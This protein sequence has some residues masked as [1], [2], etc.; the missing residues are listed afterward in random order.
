MR[1]ITIIFNNIIFNMNNQLLNKFNTTLKNLINEIK[2][3]YPEDYKNLVNENILIKLESNDNKFLDEFYTNIRNV[4]KEL[5]LKNEIIF[6]KEIVIIKGINFN[7]IWNTN[8]NVNT[9]ENL[10]KYL[11]TLYLYADNFKRSNDIS[12]IIKQYK[13]ASKTDYHN[14]DQDNQ[15]LF[16]CLDN[17]FNK[18]KIKEDDTSDPY[19]NKSDKHTATPTIPDLGIKGLGE[20]FMNNEIFGGNIGKLATEI[21]GEIDTTQLNKEDPSDL[22]QNLLSGNLSEDSP[23]IKLVHQISNKIQ[24]KLNSGEVNE[25]DLLS[26]AQGVMKSFGENKESPLNIF[27]NL[28]EMSQKMDLTDLG[29]PKNDISNNDIK[30]NQ[31]K[32]KILK[33]KFRQRKANLLSQKKKKFQIKD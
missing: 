8:I 27:Q 12:V 1:Y 10:W 18:N 6:S 28:N 17:I 22:F 5:S 30:I 4:G 21:A 14:I 9:Q 25:M 23:V 24:N 13:K 32:N 11:H 16:G 33:N 26:E 3:I 15:V 7:K 2:E 20:N 31:Q 29:I 19:E